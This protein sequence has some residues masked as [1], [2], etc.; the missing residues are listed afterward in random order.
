[1][2]NL[3]LFA[4]A[5][6]KNRWLAERQAVVAQNVANANTPGFKAKDLEPFE[7]A[8]ERTGFQLAAPRAGHLTLGGTARLS[9]AAVNAPEH[10]GSHSGNTVNIEQEMMKLGAIN[11]E[12]GLNAGILKSFQRMLMTSTRG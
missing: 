11:R 4:L 1:M 7:A 2:E 3:S 6:Q 12:Y 10:D 8:M 9:A 5:S